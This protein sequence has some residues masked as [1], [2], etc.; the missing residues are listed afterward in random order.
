MKTLCF[1]IDGTICE[2][3]ES[4]YWEAKPFAEAREVINGLYNEG[5]RIIFYTSRFMGRN[6]QNV[7]K[8]YQDGYEFTKRQLDGWGFKY[9]ELIMGK[10][11]HHINIDDKNLFFKHDWELIRNKIKEKANENIY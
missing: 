11:S 9:H 7:Q 4:K 10:P 8:T 2:Q 6:N 1:D 5:F 3:T